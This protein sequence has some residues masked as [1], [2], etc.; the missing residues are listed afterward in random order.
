MGQCS[1]DS[2]T[3]TASIEAVGAEAER[4]GPKNPEYSGGGSV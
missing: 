1:R 2:E 3:R 4:T